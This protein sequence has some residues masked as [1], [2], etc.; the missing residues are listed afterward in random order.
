MTFKK[1]LIYAGDVSPTDV[2]CALNEN[3]NA[4]LIDVRT[5]EEWAY[6]GVVDTQELNRECLFVPW[7]FFPLMTLNPDFTA[8]VRHV[9]HLTDETSPNT[10]IYF[11]CRS[12]VR[13]AFAAHR[14]NELGYDNCYNV[15]GGFEGDHDAFH[16]RGTVNGWKVA[17]LPWKQG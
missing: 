10:P 16:H 4:L 8:Q 14:F 2:W 1:D 9:A 17:G 15:A 7:L 5:P 11:I 13:S 6:V 3:A 12:G